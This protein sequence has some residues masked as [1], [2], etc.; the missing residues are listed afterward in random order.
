[1]GVVSSSTMG[2]LSPQADLDGQRFLRF[3]DGGNVGELDALLAEHLDRAY[4]QARRLLGNSSEAEDAVQEAFLRLVRS[5]SR[6]DASIPF[7]AWLG[8][9]VHRA[10]LN[11]HRARHR[12]RRYED[13]VRAQGS[14]E[15]EQAED[16]MAD[17]RGAVRDAIL[18]LPERDRAALDLQYFAGLSQRDIAK[19]LGIEEDAVAKRM[20][21]ARESLRTLLR[22][23]GVV[24][25]SASILIALGSMPAHAAPAE[26]FGKTLSIMSGASGG[27]AVS[28]G[29]TAAWAGFWSGKTAAMFLTA[30]VLSVGV[31]WWALRTA[32]TADTGHE[33]VFTF[34]V[35]G[36]GD[37]LP[38]L[39]GSWQWRPDGGVE[40][41]GCMETGPGLLRVNLQMNEIRFPAVV[42]FKFQLLDTEYGEMGAD[43]ASYNEFQWVGHFLYLESYVRSAVSLSPPRW[44]ELKIYFTDAFRYV[45][46]DGKMCNLCVYD[47]RG[48]ANIQL[49]TLGRRLIDDVRIAEIPADELPKVRQYLDA[50]ERIP[51]PERRGILPLPHLKSWKEGQQACIEFIRNA[52]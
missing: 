41:S 12:R 4:C 28:A 6:Y 3:A 50:L 8:C 11:V 27:S 5:A 10:A 14:P 13:R 40:D 25:S 18:E 9:I 37:Q 21:R 1:M 39:E 45:E 16:A 35:A 17:E 2:H 43:Y 47:R 46:Y 51:E 38:R 31:L 7:G 24:T 44:V 20:Q 26:L 15:V 32:T 36:Q 29:S 33:K 19:A 52:P 34:D 48:R 49:Y 23:R 42:S 22:R 30:L